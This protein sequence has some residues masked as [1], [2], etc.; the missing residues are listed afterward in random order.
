MD[1]IVEHEIPSRAHPNLSGS[2]LHN[3]WPLFGYVNFNQLTPGVSYCDL[4]C[5]SHVLA[6]IT[7]T[8]TLHYIFHLGKT[9][10]LLPVLG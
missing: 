5:S 10:V 4:D 2:Q 9:F 7:C 8:V 3:F 1:L 6:F